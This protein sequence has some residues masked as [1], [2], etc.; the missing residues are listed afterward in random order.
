M[1]FSGIT[2]ALKV[3]LML[4]LYSYNTDTLLTRAARISQLIDWLSPIEFIGDYCDNRL[5][6]LNHYFRKSVQGYN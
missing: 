4:F 1:I 2:H 3:T 5:I 6:V